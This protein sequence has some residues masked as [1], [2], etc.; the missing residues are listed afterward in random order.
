VKSN[1][2]TISGWGNFP[3]Q[4]C[5]LSSQR[6][7]HEIR[8]A[9]QANTFSHYIARG[10]GRAYGDSSLNEDQAVLLQTRRNRFLSFDEK[11]GILSCEAGASFEEILEHFLPQGWTLPTTPGTKYVT[12]GGAIA[13]DVHGKNH[14]RDG[15]F[16]NYVTQF[17][18]L[19]GTSEV[20]TCTPQEHA[21]VF[22][23]TIGGMGLTGVILDAQIRLQPTASA[24]FHVDYRRTKNLEDTLQVFEQSDADYRYS[25]AWID[26][27]A[28]GKFLGRSVVMLAN[29]AQ[30]AELPSIYKSQPLQLPA[31]LAAQ[32]PC[33]LPGFMLNPVSVR[34]LNHT[35]YHL[36]RNHQRWVDM[37]SFFY[38]L[39]RIGHWNRAYGRRGFIQYQALFPHQ[40][41]LA[42]LTE[43]LE[44]IALSRRASFL[45]VLKRCGSANPGPLSYLYPGHTLALDFPHTGDDLTHLITDLDQILLKNGG[46]LYLAK[47]AMMN[48]E[49]FATMYPRL[50]EFLAVKARL[51]P[52]NRFVSS[53]ARR[54]GIVPV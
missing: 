35:Y 16:G 49:T 9:L 11:T 48:A 45:A 54:L 36:H 1:P 23:A 15:S 6:V 42:G 27:L 17:R 2:Q 25:V 40:S 41:S 22:W 10:L 52:E 3:R 20:L 44:R 38:P 14:H 21:D 53:Q 8:D 30:P 19:T 43:M 7:E 5:Y 37:D 34:M 12:V 24:Y 47:D 4:S 39:D 28:H 26:G 18:L 46:R 31:K 13:A 32:V 33:N 29:D 51:D 50:P